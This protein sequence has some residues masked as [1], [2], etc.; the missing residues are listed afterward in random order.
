MNRVTRNLAVVVCAVVSSLFTIA[1]LLFLEARSG[2]QLFTYMVAN[3]VPVGA[4]GAGMLAAL[5]PLV[6]AFALRARPVP[7]VAVAMCVV[8][9][10]AVYVAQSVELTLPS[11]GRL[12]AQNPTVF[13]QYLANAVSNG[14]L[15]FTD[16]HPESSRS[17]S[18]SLNPGVGRAIPEAGA[19]GDAQVQSISTGVHGVVASQDMGTNVAA[20]GAQ[21]ISQLGDNIHDLNSNVQNHGAQWLLLGLQVLG[22]SISSLLVY[23]LL[24]SRPYCEDCHL[25]LSR[26][27]AQTRYFGGLDEINGSI[28]DVLAKAKNRR[29]QL[30]IQAHGAR[31]T[32]QKSKGTAFASTIRVSRCSRCQSHRMDFRAMRKT[33]GSWKEIPVLG[34]T[35]SSFEAIEVNS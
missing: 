30:A 3:Y 29:L 12:A 26:K 20:G 6:C 4:I 25:L 33:G 19:Q 34:Y 35:A 7:I 21:R 23:S 13:L 16:A 9:A 27:G 8:A 22:F 17:A 28:E 5:V 1:A 24:R 14:Q 32:A 15:Q 10:G 2:Q 18:V 11:A 31:G